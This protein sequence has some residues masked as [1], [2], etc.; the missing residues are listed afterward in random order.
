MS[1]ALT[2][3]EL[4]EITGKR[5]PTALTLYKPL[6]PHR[7]NWDNMAPLDWFECRLDTFLLPLSNIAADTVA[8]PQTQPP[9]D[10]G[11]Y[12]LFEDNE[13]LYVGQS[14]QIRY[15]LFRHY[16]EDFRFNRFA[17]IW[18]PKMFLTDIEY[19]YINKHL[20]PMNWKVIGS[21]YTDRVPA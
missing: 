10:V 6:Q 20:P 5:R 9:N 19:A 17:A 21:H 2:A 1:I 15:R 11:I 7:Q 16:R 8:Y 3:P 13:L 4:V 14:T 12:F 18:V